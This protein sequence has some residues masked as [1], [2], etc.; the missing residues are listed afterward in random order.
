MQKWRPN[1][2]PPEVFEALSQVYTK[3]ALSN[4]NA[5]AGKILYAQELSEREKAMASSNVTVQALYRFKGEINAFLINKTIGKLILLNEAMRTNFVLTD[6]VAAAVVFNGRNNMP[7][8][9]RQNFEKL[10]ESELMSTLYRVMDA[11]RRRNFDLKKGNLFRLMIMHVG[12]NEYLI[13]ITMS[14]LLND[15]FPIEKLLSETLSIEFT[16]EKNKAA[17][18]IANLIA[19]P[20]LESSIRDY[21]SKILTR[22]PVE[23][24][25]PYYKPFANDEH[26]CVYRAVVPYDLVSEIRSRAQ[27]NRLMLMTILQTAWGLMLQ[28]FN[29]SDDAAYGSLLPSRDKN[30]AF[31]TI[32]IRLKI[33]SDM[34]IAQLVQAQFQQLLVSQPYGRFDWS[35]LEALPGGEN[36]FNHFLNFTE[37]ISDQ[38]IFSKAN[39]TAS[40][41]LL[42]QR[43]WNAVDPRLG[44]HF[45]NDNDSISLVLKYAENRLEFDEAMQLM[46]RYL[47]TL[48]AIISDWQLTATQFKNKLSQRFK[49][50]E[51]ESL[52]KDRHWTLLHI[53]SK[54][55]ILQGANEGMLQYFAKVTQLDTRF[56]GDRISDAELEENFIILADGMLTRSIDAGD[57]WFNML[58]MIMPGLPVNESILLEQQKYKLSAE[59]ESEIAKILF[60]PLDEMRKILKQSPQLWKNIALHALDQMENYQSIWVQA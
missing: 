14:Q 26:Q 8:V 43:Y 18:E 21:W 7:E 30:A 5:N 35:M 36:V 27:G 33:A 41:E 12:P 58:D 24:Q 59:V 16:S 31:N 44:L 56:E 4:K 45:Y 9:V 42:S 22:L 1:E 40:I 50:E 20:Q 3:F 53:L 34:T 49:L 60:I 37:F 6:D 32:P 11:D 28:E 17:T 47:A 54:L 48:Q 15:A 13:L 25:V 23:Q 46:K 29:Q 2:L 52:I 38:K 39:S 10:S 19:K 57:G 55:E 51:S